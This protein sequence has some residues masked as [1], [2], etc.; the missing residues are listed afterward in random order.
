MTYELTRVSNRNSVPLSLNFDT[1]KPALQ[2]TR[3]QVTELTAADTAGPVSFRAPFEQS[4]GDTLNQVWQATRPVQGLL[5]VSYFVPVA[6]AFTSKRG[7]HIDLQAAGNGLSG[8]F[9]SFLLIPQLK[10]SL[11]LHVHW[12]LPASMTA[13]SSYALGDFSRRITLSALRTTLFLAGPIR[14]FPSHLPQGGISFYALGLSSEEL[15]QVAGWASKAYE[16]ER[17]A[18]QSAANQ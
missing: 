15:G 14:T 4:Q 3:D 12:D 13:V 11:E 7:P 16:A 17:T 6:M 18:F 8:A 2:R 1:L 5:H 9:V 10:G